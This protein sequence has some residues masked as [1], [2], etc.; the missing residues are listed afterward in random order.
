MRLARK[1]DGPVIA[2]G[3]T[4]SIPAT[5]ELIATIARLP[6]GAVVLPGLDTDLDDE[7]WRLIAGNEAKGLAPAPG[8][9]QF[10]MQALLTRIGIGRDA[11]ECLAKPCGRERLISEALRPAATTDVWRQNTV[12][13]TF[14]A[15]AEAA[16][17]TLTLIEAANAEEEALAIALVL[18]EAVHDGKTASLVT[19]DRALGRR[20]L[21]ALGRWNIAAEDSGGDAVADTPAGIFARLA[22]EAA[23]GGVEPVALLALLKHPLL[24]LGMSDRDHAAAALERA[25]LRGPRPS[26]GTA[27]LTR[28]LNTLRKTKADL[29]PSDPRTKL[30]DGELAAADKL[31]TALTDALA[32][33][34]SIA[35]A[36][37]SLADT[38]ARHRDVLAALSRD[39]GDEVAFAGPD[40][41]KLADALDELATSKAAAGL[42][43]EGRDYAELFCAALAG[44]VVRRPPRPDLQ[45]RILGLLEAR[46]TESDRVVLGGLVE[47]TW[48]PESQSD[49]W[50][51]RPMRLALGLDL[52]ERRIGLTAH[53][54][55][56]LLG[57]REV[58][59]TRAAKLEGAPTNPSR[60][61]QRLAAV[62]GT[63]WQEAVK[64]GND[65]LQWARELDRP[66]TPPRAA[67]QPAP[68]PPRAARPKGLSVT[69]IEDWLRDP[70]TIYAKHILKLRP[71][72][73]VDADPGAVER[74]TFIHAAIG[75]FTKLFA[76]QL[77]AD[78]AGE[79]HQARPQ[80][81]RRAGRFS[82]GARLLVAAL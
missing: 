81:F 2:A 46:L 45:V 78:A 67:P 41:A 32:P 29:H 34:E 66:E 10:A 63:R 70:Y 60:F 39:A 48:P 68:K 23:L 47:G 72:D 73:P 53:D 16:L 76:K 74:G 1:T 24:R 6:H 44:R 38:A 11:V 21:A 65:Y 40:G 35:A 56:Q 58:I 5:A 43:V 79:T 49:A 50:L 30:A 62:A 82:R 4:G 37:H 77:P 20:V 9:P 7:S 31:V 19:P 17:A 33:L 52:P 12:D 3:S 22:A 64:R 36:P 71:L 75:D 61:I 13:P 14:A 28:A 15:H 55:A 42:L 27:G 8:H 18:R 57:A 25:I 51:S 59:L 54:F 69:E 80:A 26:R